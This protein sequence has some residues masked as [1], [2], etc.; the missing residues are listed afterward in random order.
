MKQSGSLRIIAGKF[1]GRRVKTIDAPGTRPMTD[2]VRENLF[3]IIA[4]DLP[5]CRFL[6]IFSGS[7]AVG[8]EAIS[9]GADSAIFMEWSS[10]WCS[11]I[12]ENATTLQANGQIKLMRGDAYASIES[13]AANGATFKII[14]VGAPYDEDHHNLM[15]SKLAEFDLL[16]EGGEIILQY[17]KGN[18]LLELP[19]FS[20]SHRD[21]GITRL[22]FVSKLE[23][24]NN[25]ENNDE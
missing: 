3:N 2:R 25:S 15:M 7:G 9:R 12:E 6:D 1:R 21:Y 18:D 8:L 23:T 19:G 4:M 14:F 13:L 16:A 17:R 11:V 5:G 10:E 22:T 24:D 20:Y